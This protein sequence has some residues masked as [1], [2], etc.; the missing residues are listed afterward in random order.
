MAKRIDTPATR[1]TKA[2]QIKGITQA[3]LSRQTGIDKGTISLYVHG[4]YEPSAT[5]AVAL[6]QALNTSPEWILGFDV[7]MVKEKTSPKDDEII[8]AFENLSAAQREQVI[9]FI[10]FLGEKK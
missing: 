5:K 3:E 2:L 4:K 1:I 7:P 6:A 9:N 8:S 10:R